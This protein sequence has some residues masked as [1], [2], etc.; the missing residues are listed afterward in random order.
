MGGINP[1]P[2]VHPVAPLA[3]R[4]A[5]HSQPLSRPNGQSPVVC[6]ARGVNSELLHCSSDAFRWRLRPA[7]Y[8]RP[9]TLTADRFLGH[10]GRFAFPGRLSGQCPLKQ[11]DMRNFARSAAVS[12]PLSANFRVA[13]S[14]TCPFGAR[15]GVDAHGFRRPRSFPGA[16][17]SG[18]GVRCVVPS[19]GDGDE[20]QVA[21]TTASPDT[22]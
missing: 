16:W 4:F 13:N 8:D 21:D 17:L 3:I 18:Q 15:S 1:E 12:L 22:P 19:D 10:A 5:V 9:M 11:A 2:V 20:P 6:P 7:T 14:A